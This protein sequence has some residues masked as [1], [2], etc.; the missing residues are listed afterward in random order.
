MGDIYANAEKVLIWMGE[1]EC[2]EADECFALI[3]ETNRFLIAQLEQHKDVYAIPNIHRGDSAIC[4][5][6]RRWDLVRKLMDKPWFSRVWVLQ[7]VGLARAAV[8]HWGKS[9]MEWSQLVELMLF[10]TARA[11]IGAYTGNVKSGKIWDVFE[12]VW[13]GFENSNTWR[14]ELPL[15]RS[16]NIA[17]GQSFIDIL[18]DGRTYQTTDQ[19]DRIYAFLGHP[20]AA[21]QDIDADYQ[22]SIEE[23]YLRAARSIL[24]TCQYPWTVFS[25][26][27][28]TPD[29]PSLTGERPSWVP[30]WDESWRVY[31]LGYPDMWYRAGGHV[32]EAF[33]ISAPLSEP[34]VTLKGVIVDAIVW[35]SKAFT[36][37]ELILQQQRKFKPI[38]AAFKYMM[39]DSH[40]SC[41]QDSE[42]ALSL[43]IVAGRAANEGPAE[44]D[45]QQH[46]DAYNSYKN[47]MEESSDKACVRKDKDEQSSDTLSSQGLGIDVLTFVNNQRRAL[48]NR[49]LFRTSAGFYGAGH[50]TIESGDECCIFRG[51]NAPFVLRR[52]DAHRENKVQGRYFR[53]VG[54]SFIQGIMKGE[55]LDMLQRPG[56]KL[57]EEA[58]AII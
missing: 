51:A 24:G 54:E 38:Q 6:T 40:N 48:Q 29:S 15:T 49:R 57:I 44:D 18:N 9:S 16:M 34:R 50:M 22:V 10:V 8:I 27:D 55:V 36:S 4:S 30:R 32:P 1:D 12:D 42:L 17:G 52:V 28:H 20:R 11:D 33:E 13:R 25:T 3:L 21:E 58:I 2:S 39:Q 26:V 45:L 31:W 47:I 23:V 19:R 46:R 14:N 7:E 43:T 41:Y 53:L 35:V 37:E 56:C 5:D